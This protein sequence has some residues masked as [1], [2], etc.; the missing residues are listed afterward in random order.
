MNKK[1]FTLVELIA[2]VVILA[3]ISLIV[4]PA[5][6]SMIKNSKEK[7]YNVQI[8]EI[9]NAAKNYLSD[10]PV[11]IPEMDSNSSSEQ[12]DSSCDAVT[13]G[14]DSTISYVSVVKLVQKG[15]IST[16]DKLDGKE[17]VLNPKNVKEALDG[18]VRVAYN[19]S[20]NR[21]EYDYIEVI[22]SDENREGAGIYLLTAGSDHATLKANNGIYKSFNVRNYMKYGGRNYRILKAYTNG[23]IKIVSTDNYYS[24]RYENNEKFNKSSVYKT[25]SG[26]DKMGKVA[27]WCVGGIDNPCGETYQGNFGLLTLND[28]V[29]AS[30]KE[31]CSLAH[32]D[33]CAENNYLSSF[34]GYLMNRNSSEEGYVINS[35]GKIE[36]VSTSSSLTIY[37]VM[38]VNVN[39]N[40]GSGTIDDP[41]IA[42]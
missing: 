25:L 10:L 31:G 33:E 23:D 2:V 32:I 19:S 41:Y 11:C 20:N 6:N 30:Y 34:K 12:L 14:E 3:L 24:A 9:I 5:V 36:T 40:G 26:Y 38:I 1:G 13:R 27:S 18:Y 29:N 7:A 8:D 42:S 28:Y 4:F 21:Y 35:S 39:I 37:P 16:E 15:Y 17:V 22:P